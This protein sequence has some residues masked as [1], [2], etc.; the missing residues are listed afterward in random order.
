MEQVEEL[1]RC[2][3]TAHRYQL[4]DKAIASSDIVPENSVFYQ[5]YT[6]FINASFRGAPLFISG[7]H[8]LRTDQ[9]DAWAEKV[10]IYNE[11]GTHR[12][13]ASEYDRS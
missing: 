1:D 4:T 5:K 10:E 6:G 11:K 13:F 12:Q 2:G 3:F 8:F 7:N 9:N